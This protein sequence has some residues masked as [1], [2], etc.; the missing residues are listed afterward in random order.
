MKAFNKPSVKH[1]R[2][3][4]QG[5]NSDVLSWAIHSICLFM[6][7][8]IKPLGLVQQARRPTVAFAKKKT[9]NAEFPALPEAVC[10]SSQGIIPEDFI[11]SF[12]SVQQALGSN[13]H[14]GSDAPLS[15]LQSA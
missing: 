9:L 15:W 6:F 4:E 7:N 13:H 10:P 3:L 5:W 8:C 14:R 2:K 12:H 11:S 1:G